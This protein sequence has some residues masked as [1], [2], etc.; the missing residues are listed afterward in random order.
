MK[1]E[2]P[3]WND[4]C[5][6]AT[7]TTRLPFLLVLVATPVGR[8][9]RSLNQGVTASGWTRKFINR[10][11][12]ETTNQNLIADMPLC[13]QNSVGPKKRIAVPLWPIDFS[14]LPTTLSRSSWW[15]APWRLSQ[16]LFQHGFQGDFDF[17]FVKLGRPSINTREVFLWPKRGEREIVV[18]RSMIKKPCWDQWSITIQN[19][20]FLIIHSFHF[21]IE[22]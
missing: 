10:G 22:N 17:S 12:S 19:I 5:F 13:L 18:R 21:N 14:K 16:D 4:H 2:T 9:R 3:E 11:P 7:P 20:Y 8:W 6:F 1:K 15:V